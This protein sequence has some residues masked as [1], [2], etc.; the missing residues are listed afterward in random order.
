MTFVVR[1]TADPA[2]MTM[3]VQ[4]AIWKIG[5][6]LAVYQIDTMDAIVARNSRSLDSLTDLLLGFG[7]IALVLALGGLYGVMSFTVGQ[8]TQEIGVRMAMGADARSILRAILQRSAGLVLLGVVAGGVISW[9]L[10]RWLQ[11]LLF[12]V[13]AFDPVAYVAVASGMLAVGI[14]AGLIP[15]IRAA[16]IDPVIALRH[17]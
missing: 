2:A 12:A 15:A 16:R 14:L 11:N 13:S 10:S 9:L 4:K 1:T 5:P 6:D 3:E 7:L 17:E 8:R